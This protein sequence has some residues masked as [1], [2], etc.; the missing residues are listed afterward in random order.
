MHAHDFRSS[1]AAQAPLTARKRQ[2]SRRQRHAQALR[3]QHHH[4]ARAS[5]CALAMYS[6]CPVNAMPGLIDHALLHRRRDHRVELAGAAAV[7]RAIQ[8]RKHV[9]RIGRLSRPASARRAPALVGSDAQRAGALR[10]VRGSSRRRT[11]RSRSRDRAA[12]R[13]RCSSSRIRRQRP[14]RR[15]SRARAILQA[16][17][18]PDAGRLARGEDDSRQ[19]CA[20]PP[21]ALTSCIR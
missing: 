11:A 9:T 19:T 8:Q 14:V 20:D 6:V 13:V 10:A 17:V 5:S 4:R 15:A 18:R 12:A 7:D 2:V 21:S 1:R 3:Y 16:Q